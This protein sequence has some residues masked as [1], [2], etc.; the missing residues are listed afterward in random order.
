VER[1]GKNVKAAERIEGHDVVGM[2]AN[3][4]RSVLAHALELGNRRSGQIR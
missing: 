3:G 1:L 2:W 4:P